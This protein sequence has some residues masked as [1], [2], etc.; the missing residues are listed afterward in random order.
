MGSNQPFS[1]LKCDLWGGHFFPVVASY[2]N[3]LFFY[4]ILDGRKL[5]FTS[6]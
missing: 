1:S 3:S 5:L 4:F 2:I 6:Y